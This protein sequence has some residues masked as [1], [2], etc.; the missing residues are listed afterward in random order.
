MST[1]LK[2]N[3]AAMPQNPNCTSRSLLCSILLTHFNSF[4]KARIY[5]CSK[6]LGKKKCLWEGNFILLG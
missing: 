5:F 6:I 3:V 4:Y 2:T 1:L